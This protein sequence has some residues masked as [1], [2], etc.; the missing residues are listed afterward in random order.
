M[1]ALYHIFGSIMLI[2]MVTVLMRSTTDIQ[3]ILATV[4]GLIAFL[5]FGTGSILT[6]LSKIE[7]AL[8]RDK[9]EG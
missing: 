5:C 1:S 4:L 8:C 3:V 9:T 6:S 7:A 2:L